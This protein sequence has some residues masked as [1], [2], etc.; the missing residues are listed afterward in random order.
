MC[1]LCVGALCMLVLDVWSSLDA[2]ARGSLR[3]D[4]LEIHIDGADGAAT[5][6]SG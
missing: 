4:S 5:I 2:V 6:L 3:N 1:V